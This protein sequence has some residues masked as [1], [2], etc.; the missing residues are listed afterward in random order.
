MHTER[1][2]RAHDNEICGSERLQAMLA[3][4]DIN[5]CASKSVRGDRFDIAPHLAERDASAP[6]GEQQRR[7]HSAASRAHDGDVPSMH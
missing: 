5:P 1:H 4:L 7:R 2:A 3:E 6:F